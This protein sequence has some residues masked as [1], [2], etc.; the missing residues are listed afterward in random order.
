MTHAPTAETATAGWRW[1]PFWVL[2]FVALWP[3]PG[4]AE[5]V[6]ILGALAA[7]GRLS[8]LAAR[9]QRS[10]GAP[11]AVDARALGRLDTAGASLLLDL[12]DGDTTRI[13]APPAAARL[14][15]TVAGVQIP[16][17]PERLA[18]KMEVARG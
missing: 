6:M 11:L 3:M 2:A 12:V 5:A 10:A 17:T 14:I 7:I 9:C 16:L 18:A 15:A 8:A 1:A 4:I 13:D